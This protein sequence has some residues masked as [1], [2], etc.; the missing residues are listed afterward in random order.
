MEAFCQGDGLMR[1]SAVLRF[2]QDRGVKDQAG[3]VGV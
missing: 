2:L 3:A 1:S